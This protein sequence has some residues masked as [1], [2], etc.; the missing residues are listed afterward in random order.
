MLGIMVALHIYL[1][2]MK[3]KMKMKMLEISDI[4]LMKIDTE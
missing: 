4:C 2:N 3:M 1:F